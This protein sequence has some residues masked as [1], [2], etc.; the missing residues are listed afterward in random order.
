V[1]DTLPRIINHHC[2]LIR[3]NPISPLQHKIPHIGIEVLFLESEFGIGKADLLI[4]F[5][6]KAPSQCRT[7][8]GKLR[9]PNMAITAGTGVNLLLVAGA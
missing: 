6:G 5:E 1:R 7:A 8:I 2:E 4:G 9:L 3:K